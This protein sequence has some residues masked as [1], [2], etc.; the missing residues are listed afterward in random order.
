MQGD[1]RETLRLA[2]CLATERGVEIC[3][4][5]HDAVLI[6]APPARVSSVIA[7]HALLQRMFHNGWLNLVAIDPPALQAHRYHTD[8]TWEPLVTA[9]RT[10]DH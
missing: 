1:G 6:E 4:P 10:A 2:C 5:V 7:R 9:P 3:A 8:G